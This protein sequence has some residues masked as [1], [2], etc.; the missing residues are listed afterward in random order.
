VCQCGKIGVP[1]QYEK[2]IPPFPALSPVFFPEADDSRL[3][4]FGVVIMI[5]ALIWWQQA[6]DANRLNHH[7]KA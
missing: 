3:T 1:V 6:R 7:Q 5:T 4:I 2:V